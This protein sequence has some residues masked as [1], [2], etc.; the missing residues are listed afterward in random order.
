M[1]I[2]TKRS[3]YS[4]LLLLSVGLVVLITLGFGCADKKDKK[5]I[6][7]DKVN[8]KIVLNQIA[9][10]MEV[11]KMMEE[12]SPS[13]DMKMMETKGVERGKLMAKPDYQ[14]EGTLDD[15]TGNSAT[16][17]ARASFEN[18]AYKLYA[19][20]ANL[21]ALTGTDFYEGW[22]VRQQPFHFISTGNAKEIG[23]VFNNLYQSEQD[24]TD[25]N[26]YVLTLEPDDG[27]PAP[28]THIVEGV[29]L[30]L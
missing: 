19:S 7:Y 16:G 28:A 3:N 25:H 5:A 18:G 27:D 1:D 11:M 15:V 22:I 6:D 14:Y 30:K 2:V 26:F 21:P 17:L 9:G 24:L 4:S 8:E 20:F 13:E 23:G 12:S 29:M 10:K